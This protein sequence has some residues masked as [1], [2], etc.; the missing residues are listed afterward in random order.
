MLWSSPKW[1]HFDL[2][3]LSVQP[4]N[5]VEFDSLSWST[6]SP[7]LNMLNSVEFVESGDL[8]RPNVE[9]PYDIRSLRHSVDFVEFNKRDRV[10]FDF[11]TIVYQALGWS[12]HDL[13]LQN[14]SVQWSKHSLYQIW[15][16][17]ASFK[18]RDRWMERNLLQGDNIMAHNLTTIIV[19]SKTQVWHGLISVFVLTK[20]D[21]HENM[22][23]DL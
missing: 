8:C 11:V 17:V 18:R 15:T 10:E 6:L 22:A 20:C 16:G 4:G 9:C 19:K 21:L 3:C 13:C 5:K 12:V 1:R 2:R 14:C 23:L 7:K